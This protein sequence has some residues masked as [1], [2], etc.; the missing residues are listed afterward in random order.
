[1][2]SKRSRVFLL[3]FD[4]LLEARDDFPTVGMVAKDGALLE[5]VLKMI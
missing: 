2:G 1:M 5:P 4:H 3:G